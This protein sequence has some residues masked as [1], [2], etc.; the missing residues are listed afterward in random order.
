MAANGRRRESL[1]EPR[2]HA[3]EV[4]GHRRRVPDR[5]RPLV[6]RPGLAVPGDWRDHERA[7]VRR[8]ARHA[9]RRPAGRRARRLPRRLGDAPDDGRVRVAAVPVR[10]WRAARPSDR[11]VSRGHVRSNDDRR[12][13]RHGLR[14]AHAVTRHVAPVHAVARRHGDHR[15]RG[16]GAAPATR[17]GTADARVGASRTRDRAARRARTGDRPPALGALR[18]VDGAA[19]TAPR[20]GRLARPRRRHDTVRGRRALFFDAAD[21]RILDQGQTRS[22]RSLP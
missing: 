8:R 15:A 2:R 6:R 17:R 1:R 5:R 10:R 22:P 4:P 18:R 20:S 21:R 11:R 7:R 13:R 16:R 9:R 19:R 14:R 12:E 3:R